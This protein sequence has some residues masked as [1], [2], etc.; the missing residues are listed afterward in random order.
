M[1][2]IAPVR[3][4][5][6]TPCSSASKET[7]AVRWLI[8]KRAFH[9]ESGGGMFDVCSHIHERSQRTHLVS[10]FELLFFHGGDVLQHP[11]L[12]LVKILRAPV[13]RAER[14][15]RVALVIA[16]HLGRGT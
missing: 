1:R 12:H 8:P 16:D 11:A 10:A 3:S 14:A 9:L 6:S 5:S 2:W 15:Q 7:R 13:N 4:T